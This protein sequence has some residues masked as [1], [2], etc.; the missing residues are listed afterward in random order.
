MSILS[1]SMGSLIQDNPY[2]KDHE[3]SFIAF[4]SIAL[5]RLCKQDV[6]KGHMGFIYLFAQRGPN[7]VSPLHNLQ[8]HSHM[9]VSCAPLGIESTKKNTIPVP[10]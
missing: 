3:R 2:F 5:S 6:S 1:N 4:T 10:H 9:N 8:A 7:Y